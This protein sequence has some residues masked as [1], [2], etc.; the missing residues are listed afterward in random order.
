MSQDCV[1]RYRRTASESGWTCLHCGDKKAISVDDEYMTNTTPNAHQL[2]LEFRRFLSEDEWRDVVTRAQELPYVKH[3]RADA[4][5]IP[6]EQV[7]EK[8]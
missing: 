8:P 6:T 2:T 5:T 4:V 3:L 1:H 7:V